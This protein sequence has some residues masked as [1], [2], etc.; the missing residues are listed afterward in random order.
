MYV[1]T[2]AHLSMYKNNLAKIC[3]FLQIH[4]QPWHLLVISSVQS[5]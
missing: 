4:I 2:C 1:L 5:K 3:G